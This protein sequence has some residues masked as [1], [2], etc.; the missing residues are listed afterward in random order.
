M[1]AD[2][3]IKSPKAASAVLVGNRKWMERNG[4]LVDSIVDNIMIEEEQ[5][6]RI[7]VLCAIDSVLTSIISVADTMKPEAPLA[8]YSLKKMGLDVVLL[9]GD[10]ARTARAIA[11]QVRLFCMTEIVQ[12][13]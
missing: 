8:V 12:Q 9:T 6:G 5:M 10:N 13:M 3:D 7:A 1:A 2:L 11:K 4:I